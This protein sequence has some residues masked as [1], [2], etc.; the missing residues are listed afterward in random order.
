MNLFSTILSHL[1]QGQMKNLNIYFLLFFLSANI[2]LSQD[3]KIN[4]L[5][6]LLSKSENEK[7][8]EILHSLVLEL[9]LTSPAKAE[10]YA[11]NAIEL[12]EQL[13]DT[14]LQ[15][16]SLRLLGGVYIYKGE[17]D[18]SLS[19]TRKALSLGYQINDTIL[20]SSSLNNLGFIHYNL[21]NYSE[22]F[23]NCYR[24]LYLKKRIKPDYAL[25][26][27]LNNVGLIYLELKDYG[28]AET[29]FNEAME[30]SRE[31]MDM[32]TL[33][34]S[35]NNIGFT[36]LAQ[37]NFL[38]AENYFKQAERIAKKNNYKNWQAMACSGLGQTYYQT[39]SIK[40]AKKQFMKALD[41]RN[42]IRDLKGISEIYYYLS[43]MHSLTSELDSAFH[44]VKI[45]Q[46]IAIQIQAKD[47]LL[48]N[49]NLFKDLYLQK[50]RYDSA[51]Y[52][53]NLY[54]DLRE[55]QF[56]ENSLRSIEGIELKIQQE[57]TLK[58]LALRDL[59][60]NQKSQQA[61]FIAL[62]AALALIFALIIFTNYLKQKKL[63]RD[64]L[65]KNQKI[66]HQKNEIVLKN[67]K[68]NAMDAEKNNL[69][70][71]VAHDLKN[72]LNNIIALTDII[73]LTHEQDRNK[74][75]E[76]LDMIKESSHRLINLIKKIL[77]TESIE[78]QETRLNLEK[79]NL[80]EKVVSIIH[81][82]TLEAEQKKIQLL[83]SLDEKVTA[84]VDPNYFE[85]IIENLLSNAIKFSTFEKS[86]FINLYTKENKAICEIKDQGQGL[87][88][89]DKEKLFIKYQKLSA[90][91]TN[92]ETSTGLGL[93]IVKKYVDVMQGEIWCESE[94][95]KGTSFFVSFEIA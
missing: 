64:L 54:V 27:M 84:K 77:N 26:N 22:A 18:L 19:Y 40:A 92:N 88:A 2:G 66:S 9:W 62:T 91:P 38:K 10:E 4:N 32:N 50:K 20:I 33:A 82:F 3:S 55:S 49:L 76:Y 7:R 28:T 86:V 17:Y 75:Q 59:E 60:L 29:Y 90:T 70:G 78:A 93:S 83:T 52:S 36:F 58:K 45:S 1:K 42:E 51:F 73:K 57:E 21:G 69:I 13:E 47:R 79:I 68:L 12:S 85:Q 25:S 30:L 56:E 14:R 72:P 11:N 15:S 53:Q 43:T 65:I 74:T 67:K 5:E 34:Y 63:G 46:N 24:A 94:K 37:Q 61:N 48:K 8:V 39:D 35:L 16:I 81:R 87:D 89:N 31:I 23:D 95:D 71:I 44:Y 41:L 6:D 80:S